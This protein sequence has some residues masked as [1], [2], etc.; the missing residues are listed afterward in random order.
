MLAARPNLNGNS[1]EDFR[2]AAMRLLEARE[3]VSVALSRI[4]TDVIH[5]RNYQTLDCERRADGMV[6]D[7]CLVE[8]AARAALALDRLAEAIAEALEARETACA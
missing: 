1:A 7:R 3:G 8:E 2:R 4:R 5:G 6:A